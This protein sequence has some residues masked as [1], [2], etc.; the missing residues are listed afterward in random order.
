MKV[1]K[2]KTGVLVV[3]LGGC[4]TAGAQEQE[5][6]LK[7]EMTLER[8]YDPTVQDANKINS[9]PEIKAPEVSKRPIDY[10]NFTTPADPAQEIHVLPSGSVMTEILYNKRR[11]YFNFGGGMYANLNGD[12]GYRILD[13]DK[14][15]L[16]LY[17]THRSTNGN[18]KFPKR[19]FYGDPVDYSLTRKAKLNDNL[20][21]LD[22]EHSFNYNTVLR[23][24]ASYGY[25][26]FN[27]YGLTD[28]PL[29]ISYSS[30]LPAYMSMLTEADTLTNQ[31]NQTFQ[32]NAGVSGVIKE[33]IVYHLDADFRHFGQK[34]GWS[35]S[36][37]GVNENIVC[38]RFDVSSFLGSG[39]NQR[40]GL[41]GDFDFHNYKYPSQ[42]NGNDTAGYHN[43]M[44][45]VLTP[46]YR[47][48][49]DSWKVKLGANVMFI[50]GD[51]LKVFASPNLSAEAKVADK[52]V[53]YANAT[54]EIG[55]NDPYS[56]SRRNRYMDHS[57]IVEHSRTWLDATV[58]IRSNVA[59]SCRI[60]VFAGYK[61]TKD[62]IFFVP[63][64]YIDH[65]DGI[66][67]EIPTVSNMDFVAY[68]TAVQTDASLFH[69][70][71]ALKYAYRKW[72][73]F[74][75]R[76]V[77]NQWNVQSDGRSMTL[78]SV[79]DEGMK[80]YGRPQY[81]V[82]ADLSVKPLTPL[83][84]TLNYYL[85]GGRYSL[86]HGGEEVKMN[87]LHDLNLTTSWNFNDTFGAWVKLNNLL[88]R[89]Q[90]VFYGYYLQGFNVM[91]G[92]NINF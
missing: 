3:L 77:Y 81:E 51:S 9:L 19:N 23:L 87:D 6:R 32:V 2:I 18:V 78:Y 72:V 36:L 4:L 10:A 15:N 7:R 17:A 63:G 83:T 90:E 80:P 52:A 85:G 57:A 61:S 89:Q 64:V 76:G 69:V 47:I 71:A 41:A 21:G 34:Y 8:E 24:G 30:L 42:Y 54:G 88:F 48:E 92:I 60:D 62:D 70:G 58:G 31:V 45:A 66:S 56:L 53:F 49:G 43:H 79:G 84:L 39:R 40:A 65:I 14:D 22:F 44:E 67:S 91:A 20:V 59:S 26:A 16:S 37:K 29:F 50:T 46:Y 75:L 33:K 74:S 25:T 11:G 68:Q 5:E 38:A 1:N 55:T 35:K 86:L 12:F 28:N 82:N 73:D 13:S 27:Y